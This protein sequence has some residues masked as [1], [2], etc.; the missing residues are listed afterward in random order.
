MK[1]ATTQPEP[2]TTLNSHRAKCNQCVSPADLCPEGEKLF[3]K[4]YEEAERRARLRRDVTQPVSP[5]GETL[6]TLPLSR[7]R[8]AVY[9]SIYDASERLIAFVAMSD[10][11]RARAEQIVTA[12]NAYEAN[13]AELVRLRDALAKMRCTCDA[14]SRYGHYDGPHCNATVARAALEGKDSVDKR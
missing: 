2:P 3:E 14:N 13:Q 8:G 10:N 1:S 5:Q 11:S 6:F 4:E 9:D 7:R 12:V